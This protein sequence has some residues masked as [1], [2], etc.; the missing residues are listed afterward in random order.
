MVC[1]AW[2]FSSASLSVCDLEHEVVARKGTGFLHA[3]DV[4]NLVGK[5]D[6]EEEEEEARSALNSVLL[7]ALNGTSAPDSESAP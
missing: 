5:E 2:I 6:E 7:G 1:A 4:E 3:G